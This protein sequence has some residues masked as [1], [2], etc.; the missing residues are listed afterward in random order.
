[1]E[2]IRALADQA[3]RDKFSIFL[4]VV[5]LG[6]LVLF[7]RKRR[8]AWLVAVFTSLGWGYVSVLVSAWA[9]AAFQ[10]ISAVYC[11]MVWSVHE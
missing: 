10:V 7:A 11:Y 3:I 4:L 9:M 6:D 5:G 1:M 2:E 8:E